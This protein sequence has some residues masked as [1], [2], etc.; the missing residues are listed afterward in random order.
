MQKPVRTYYEI[1]TL[2]L[3]LLFSISTLS[4]QSKAGDF[5]HFHPRFEPFILPGGP[6]ASAVQCVAQDKLGFLWLASKK[7]LYRFDGLQFIIYRHDPRD[8]TSIADDYVEWVMVDS[9]GILWLGY[10][11]AGV[12]AFNPITESCVHYHPEP[13]NPDALS[14]GSVA[15]IV[16]DRQGYI[17]VGTKEGL[18]RLDRKTGK[19]K[20]FFHDPNDP[21]SL[22]YNFVRSLYVDR[23][24]TLW[25][26]CGTLWDGNDL[27]G[28]R[29]GLNRFNPDGTFTR[30]LNDPED[31]NS[32]G[33]NRV[34]AIFEDSRGNF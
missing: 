26:G 5:N 22:S 30:F 31:P 2:T 15:M 17:W 10:W 13:G 7:G 33:D 24:G 8:S 21:H 14:D 23:S 18:N 6:E 34:R 19:F 12:S 1:A 20:R 11:G 9:K 27:A 16:E 29:G 28:K 4:A 25:V 3:L 32:L